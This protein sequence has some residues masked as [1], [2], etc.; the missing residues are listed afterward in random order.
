MRAHSRAFCERLLVLFL[1]AW[2][3]GSI[4]VW[5]VVV[6]NFA[7]IDHML[8]RNPALSERAGF[9]PADEEGRK[10]SVIWVHSSELNRVFFESWCTAQLVLGAASLLVAFAVGR[11]AVIAPLAVAAA[12]V[13]YQTWFLVPD[14]VELGRALDFAPRDPPPPELAEFG[15]R[16]GLYL[17]VD[18]TRV[19]AVAVAAVAAIW[20]GRTGG[21]RRRVASSGS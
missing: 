9:D 7:G 14:I 5:G 17:G 13:V 10:T 8:S 11:G 1:G 19:V 2:L 4:V 16:H 20:G 3:G 6:Y 12:L 18:M 21:G 15:K